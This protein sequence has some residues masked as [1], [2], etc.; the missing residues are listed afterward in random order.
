MNLEQVKDFIKNTDRE[1]LTE[2][3]KVYNQSL[4]NLI[5]AE[6]DQF[7]VGDEVS[8]EHHSVP[9]DHIFKVIRIN[10]KSVTVKSAIREIKVS[11]KFLRKAKSGSFPTI[12]L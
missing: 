10:K 9:V 11:P 3:A 2:I 6:A 7:K 1:T 12:K 4:N 8:I 5:K